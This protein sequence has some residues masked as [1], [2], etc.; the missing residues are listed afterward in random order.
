MNANSDNT[1]IGKKFQNDVDTCLSKEFGQGFIPE[2]ALPIGTPAHPHKFDLVSADHT[3][4]VECKCY[5][6]TDGGNI[7]SA[8]IATLDEALFY[9][10]FLPDE[11]IKIIALNKAE[12]PGKTETFAAYFYRMRKHLLR[13]VQVYEIDSSGGI[14]VYKD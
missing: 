6:W 10:S 11:V 1:S 5:T 7:P 2:V 14:K 4:V 9:M 12:T 13:N 3:I 8:K